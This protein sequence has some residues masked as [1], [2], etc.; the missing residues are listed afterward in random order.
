MGG[1][2]DAFWALRDMRESSLRAFSKAEEQRIFSPA[3]NRSGKRYCPITWSILLRDADI[4]ATL[5]RLTIFCDAN[6]REYRLECFGLRGARMKVYD[7]YHVAM[8]HVATNS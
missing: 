3:Q 2:F 5:R 7:F 6:A 1:N 4:E 8:A